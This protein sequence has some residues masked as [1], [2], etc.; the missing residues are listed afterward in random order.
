ML[1]KPRAEHFRTKDDFY[2]LRAKAPDEA[3]AQ[4]MRLRDGRFAWFE[5]G[6]LAA[7]VKGLTDN[8]HRVASAG[9]MTGGDGGAQ[10]QLELREDPNALFY[11]MG[12]TLAEAE[13]FIGGAA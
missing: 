11:K 4:L 6:A 13:A 7:G 12:W 9:D 8:T 10:V 2:Q 1:G 5:T 3:K